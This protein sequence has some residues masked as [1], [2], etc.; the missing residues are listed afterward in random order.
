[1]LPEG[2]EV[3][4]PDNIVSAKELVELDKEREVT[5]TDIFSLYSLPKA[6]KDG[7]YSKSSVSGGI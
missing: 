7:E 4:Y 3:I 5:K 2:E 1:M 6:S